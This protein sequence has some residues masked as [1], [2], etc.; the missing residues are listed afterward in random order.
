MIIFEH[1]LVMTLSMGKAIA[2][3]NRHP[4]DQPWQKHSYAVCA[5]MWI[6]FWV[7]KLFFRTLVC[8]R[9]KRPKKETR[10]SL[11]RR[12]TGPFS[13]PK[14]YVKCF[15]FLRRVFPLLLCQ[16]HFPSW[17]NTCRKLR[18][19]SQKVMSKNGLIELVNVAEAFVLKER[20]YGVCGLSHYEQKR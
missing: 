13:R 12:K 1:F 14:S 8:G 10:A 18:L 7:Q 15:R 17:V 9:K 4:C 16:I 3:K 2:Q 19:G 5:F 6:N 20:L 11:L